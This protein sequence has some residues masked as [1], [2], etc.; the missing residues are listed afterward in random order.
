MTCEAT[1]SSVAGY[2]DREFRDK[3]LPADAWMLS[4]HAEFDNCLFD[5]VHHLEGAVDRW[6]YTI[7]LGADDETIIRRV[8]FEFGERKVNGITGG[9]SWEAR[10]WGRDGKLHIGFDAVG[11]ALED[12]RLAQ[13]VRDILQIPRMEEMGDYV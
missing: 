5:A 3:R 6:V 10:A 12:G 9:R 7:G 13:R 11:R 4:E 2:E 1:G 8:A